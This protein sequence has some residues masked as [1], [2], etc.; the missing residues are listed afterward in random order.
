MLKKLM[1]VTQFAAKQIQR[2]QIMKCFYFIHSLVQKWKPAEIK[3]EQQMLAV[4]GKE[5]KEPRSFFGG[6]PTHLFRKHSDSS[7]M[8]PYASLNNCRA[9]EEISGFKNTRFS[10]AAT[11]SLSP[12][13]SG[14]PIREST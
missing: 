11:K 3:E 6:S 9:F 8:L 10:S 1:I 4:R 2:L 7:T 12:I 5:E 13:C 14:K